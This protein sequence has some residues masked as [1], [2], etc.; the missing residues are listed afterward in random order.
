[1]QALKKSFKV[2]TTII[3]A[4][5][6]AVATLLTAVIGGIFLLHAM[7]GPSPNTIP[8]PGTSGVLSP[9]PTSVTLQPTIYTYKA[10]VP[11]PCDT[12]GGSWQISQVSGSNPTYECTSTDFVFHQYGSTNY[13]FAEA[14]LTLPS[15]AYPEQFHVTT[16]VI[17]VSNVCAGLIVLSNAGYGGYSGVICSDGRWLLRRYTSTGAPIDI[18]SG[19]VSPPG[20]NLEL[21]VTTSTVAFFINGNQVAYAPRGSEYQSNFVALAEYNTTAASTGTANFNGFTH[22]DN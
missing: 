11:G 16:N 7:A 6:G 22:S 5:I 15:H 20:Y 3:A 21:A 2:D 9:T 19:N 17:P 8:T 1:M 10:P 18:S 14:G 13:D 4:I 12:N